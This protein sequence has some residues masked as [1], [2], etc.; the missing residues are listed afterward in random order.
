[1]ES[2]LGWDV[3]G[4]VFGIVLALGLGVLAVGSYGWA[5]FWF[6]LA[7]AILATKLAL[8]AAPIWPDVGWLLLA[9]VIIGV[10]LLLAFRRVAFLEL[11][12]STRLKPGKKPTPSHQYLDGVPEAALVVFLGSNLAWATRMPHTILQMAALK[13][14]V[15]DRRKDR[16]E[17]VVSVLRI[18]DDRGNIIARIGEGD[19]WVENSTRKKRPDPSTLVV[20]DRSDTEVLHIKFPNPTT[21]S[22]TG[23]FRR[24]GGPVAVTITPE[25]LQIGGMKMSGSSMGEAGQA[26]IFVDV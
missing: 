22:V 25:V 9:F 5:K 6:S 13:M 16:N 1:M 17:L 7:A 2:L 15:I 4:V 3:I 8:I 18:F 14:L 24:E 23:V 21:L 26:D 19:F 10:S 12:D 11:R 20:Y